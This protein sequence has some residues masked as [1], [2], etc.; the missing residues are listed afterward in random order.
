MNLKSILNTTVR[1]A[2]E[3]GKIQRLTDHP[4]PQSHQFNNY[5]HTIK[6]PS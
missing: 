2:E 6:V 4:L 1:E 3:D 5:Q